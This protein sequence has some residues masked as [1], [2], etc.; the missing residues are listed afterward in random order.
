MKTLAAITLALAMTGPALAESEHR[1]IDAADLRMAPSKYLDKPIELR[2]MYCYYADDEDYR[3]VASDSTLAVFAPAIESEAE[4]SA[5]EANCGEMKKITSP[6]CTKTIRLVPASNVQ[7]HIS[8]Y[9][10]RTVI[11]TE[12]IEIVPATTKARKAAR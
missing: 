2:R 11:R 4:K 12:T 1:V 10:L 6:A 8:G 9:M 5:L 3:C 7:D